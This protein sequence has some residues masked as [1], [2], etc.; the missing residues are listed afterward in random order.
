MS[1]EAENKVW[2]VRSVQAARLRA[3]VLRAAEVSRRRR[4]PTATV[5]V[6]SWRSA[7]TCG[8]EDALARYM[9]NVVTYT[10]REASVE[11]L[12]ERTTW[13]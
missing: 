10:S 11:E 5:P 9:G 2:I 3:V 12:P 13:R 7:L 6:A 8:R 1:L 4:Q